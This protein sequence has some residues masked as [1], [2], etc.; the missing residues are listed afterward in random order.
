MQEIIKIL[1][2]VSYKHSILYVFQDFIALM[3]L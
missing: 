3:A 1:E 2:K